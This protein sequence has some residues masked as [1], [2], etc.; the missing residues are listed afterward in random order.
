MSDRF[1]EISVNDGLEGIVRV[2]VDGFVQIHVSWL[3][4]LLLD[5]G[6]TYEEVSG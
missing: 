6:R 3:K 4:G 2:E 1:L 5:A